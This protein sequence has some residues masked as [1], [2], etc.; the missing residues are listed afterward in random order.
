MDS[1]TPWPLGYHGG[2]GCSKKKEDW[3]ATVLASLAETAPVLS[4]GTCLFLGHFFLLSGDLSFSLSAE[5]QECCKT[6]QSSLPRPPSVPT[7]SLPSRLVYPDRGP[8]FQLRIDTGDHPII[9]VR[10]PVRAR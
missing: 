10:C 5:K 3:A 1:P 4:D 7:S 6:P 2:G 9:R 8:E